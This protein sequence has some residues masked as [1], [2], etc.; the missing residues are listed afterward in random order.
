[1]DL[2]ADIMLIFQNRGKVIEYEIYY[3]LRFKVVGANGDV[4]VK[5]QQINMVRDYPFVATEVIG[6]SNEEILLRDDMYKDMARQI[7]RRIQAQAS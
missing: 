1:M 3:L 7:M 6:S 4:I 5:E 2:M